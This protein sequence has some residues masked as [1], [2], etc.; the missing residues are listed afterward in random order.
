[1]KAAGLDVGRTL[2][3]LSLKQLLVRIAEEYL[4]WMVRGLP[5]FSGVYLRYFFVKACARKVEG[6][7]W[8]SRG[9]TFA[10]TYNLTLGKQ[11]SFGRNVLLDALGGLEIGTNTGV[12]PNAII[13]AQ[14]HS[15]VDRDPMGTSAHRSK[16]IKIGSGCFVGAATFIKAGI[17]LGDRCVVAANSNVVQDVP[18]NGWVI[19]VP[20]RPYPQV[21]REMLRAERKAR[22]VAA[23]SSKAI[24]RDKTP[25]GEG[26]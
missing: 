17:T 10:N 1:M 18:E 13:L 16:P 24:K 21:M 4:W 20:A 6:F 25:S 11:V 7:C 9:C 12:G 14:E 5:G 23:G 2:K 22:G 8:I 26:S 19:G 15:I 3:S